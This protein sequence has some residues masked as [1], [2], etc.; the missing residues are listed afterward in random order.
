MKLPKN[1]P[2]LPPVPEGYSHW[3]YRGM[4]WDNNEIPTTYAVS[5]GSVIKKWSVSINIKPRGCHNLHY[6]EA[7]KE[8]ENKTMKFIYE[9]KSDKK[10]TFACVEL[11]QFYVSGGLLCQKVSDESYNILALSTGY[12][13]SDHIKEA[14]S[15]DP[16]D[17][18]LPKVIKIEF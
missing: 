18:I 2:P 3:E 9:D 4:G 1:I 7:I 13:Y 10:L 6:M 5:D 8:E 12:P 16:I 15:S 17:R 11:N 14:E